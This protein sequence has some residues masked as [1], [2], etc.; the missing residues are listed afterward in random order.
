MEQ[1]LFT[2]SIAA[3]FLLRIGVPVIVLITVGVVI[4]RWQSHRDQHI[5]ATSNKHA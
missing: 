3:L 4:D 2:L 5:K 1:L